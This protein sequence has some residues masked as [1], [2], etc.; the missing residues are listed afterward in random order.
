MFSLESVKE[1]FDEKYENIKDEIENWD[2]DK[3]KKEIKQYIYKHRFFI[4][5]AP[6]LILITIITFEINLKN[7][8]KLKFKNIKQHGGDNNNNISELKN[9]Q[10]ES[11]EQS[12]ENSQNT[13]E[14]T[15]NSSDSNNKVKDENTGE[16]EDKKGLREKLGIK[17]KKER[18]ERQAE[19][20]EI[21]NKLLNKKKKK[22]DRKSEKKE[23]KGMGFGKAL[24]DGIGKGG[25]A[26][27][28]TVMK[29]FKYIFYFIAAGFLIFLPGIIYIIIVYLVI[30]KLVKNINIL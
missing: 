23:R 25:S 6:I 19:L 15:D 11:V 28:K 1:N 12:G 30:R 22:D 4:I 14:K 21:D 16:G 27:K 26:I 24:K 20:N 13:S 10:N 17:T 9:V 2:W 8:K 5:L 3:K 29:F 7:K 18:E